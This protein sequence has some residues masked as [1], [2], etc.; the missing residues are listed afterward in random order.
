M[1]QVPNQYPYWLGQ[2]STSSGV[3]LAA[4]D[5][6]NILASNVTVTNALCTTTSV[7]LLTPILAAGGNTCI[8]TVTTRS[9]GS[10]VINSPAYP[11][12][13]KVAYF[14]AAAVSNSGL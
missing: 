5:V 1:S 8:P 14:I 6:V 7:I 3:A 12:N 2:A 13:F 4:S 10:F 9:A 11:A